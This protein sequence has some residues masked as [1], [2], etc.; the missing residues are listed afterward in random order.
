MGVSIFA[1][2]EAE[3]VPRRCIV[4]LTCDADHGFFGPETAEFADP[5]L[6]DAY[7][8]AGR[9]GWKITS[10]EVRCPDHSGKK[11]CTS[12]PTMPHER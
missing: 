8:R 1:V 5:W 7:T 3:P 11:R 6:P 10:L 4:R 2:D 12:T 9:L